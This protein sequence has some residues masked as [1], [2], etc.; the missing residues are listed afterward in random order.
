MPTKCNVQHICKWHIRVVSFVHCVQSVLDLD[1]VFF[2]HVQYVRVC[3]S[4]LYNFDTFHHIISVLIM[5]AL[6]FVSL[7]VSLQFSKSQRN[8]SKAHC[9]DC[10]YNAPTFGNKMNIGRMKMYRVRV[11]YAMKS[12]ISH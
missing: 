4:V 12:K 8:Y 10:C 3:V 9:A 11:N 7:F 1:L 5:F 6:F 2:I